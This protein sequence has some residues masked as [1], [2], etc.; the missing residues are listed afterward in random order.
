MI[1]TIQMIIFSLIVIIIFHYLYESIKS[2]LTRPIIKNINLEDN[3]LK[4]YLT[5]K[6]NVLNTN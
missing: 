1:Q 3:E 2:M 5:S 4:S 6:I